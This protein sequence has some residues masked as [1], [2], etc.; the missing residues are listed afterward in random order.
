MAATIQSPIASAAR[1]GLLSAAKASAA[2][3]DLRILHTSVAASTGGVA[4]GIQS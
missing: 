4:V 3:K 1:T 2:N